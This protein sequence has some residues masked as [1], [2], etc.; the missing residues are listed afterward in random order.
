M[1]SQYPI[2]SDEVENVIDDEEEVE[3]SELDSDAENRESSRNRT[4]ESP[5]DFGIA[6]RQKLRDELARQVD[7]FLA[8]GG[9]IHELPSN[10]NSGR[11]KK[12]V[13]DFGDRAV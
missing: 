10:L 6:S 5:Q 1:T 3:T 11:P 2:E 13:S 12:P 4:G 9:R 7:V 8:R